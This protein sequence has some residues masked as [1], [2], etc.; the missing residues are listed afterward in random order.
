MNLIDYINKLPKEVVKG[1][2]SMNYGFDEN[3]IEFQ[4]DVDEHCCVNVNHDLNV[5]ELSFVPHYFEDGQDYKELN[6][7]G[8][9]MCNEIIN[10]FRGKE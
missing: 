3:D 4:F 2:N 1:L 8:V 10:T 9:Q 6:E 5:N 7:K